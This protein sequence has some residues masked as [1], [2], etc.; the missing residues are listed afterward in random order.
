M[1]ENHSDASHFFSSFLKVFLGM[2][3]E[4]SISTT[5]I[6]TWVIGSRITMKAKENTFSISGTSTKVNGRKEERTEKA[7]TCGLTVC[8]MTENGKTI[9]SMGK[10]STSI[11]ME[12]GITETM[13]MDIDMVLESI[14]GEMD[15]ILWVWG[16]RLDCCKSIIKRCREA[17]AMLWLH[18]IF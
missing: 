12:D 8:I 7:Y 13:R 17:K 10:D 1:N 18:D 16:N 14:I 2:V 4:R 9:K 15:I 6:V 3:L 11:N 5:G